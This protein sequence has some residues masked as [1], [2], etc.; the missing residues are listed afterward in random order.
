[1][2]NCVLCQIQASFFYRIYATY[3]VYQTTWRMVRDHG[4]ENATRHI[5]TEIL[6]VVYVKIIEEVFV[7]KL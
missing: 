5:V 3:L 7:N 4:H 6:R 1:M 2:Q